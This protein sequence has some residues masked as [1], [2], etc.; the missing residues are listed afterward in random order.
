MSVPGAW[1]ILQRQWRGTPRSGTKELANDCII[2]SALH[3]SKQFFSLTQLLRILDDEPTC[4]LYHTCKR[5]DGCTSLHYALQSPTRTPGLQIM[6]VSRMTCTRERT[7]MVGQDHLISI[8]PFMGGIRKRALDPVWQ[9]SVIAM[10]VVD[11]KGVREER[12]SV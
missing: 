1:S 5:G 9:P 6:P 8:Q 2:S 12:W 4:S 7:V 11:G 3:S 10:R